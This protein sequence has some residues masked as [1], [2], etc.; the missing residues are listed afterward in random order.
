MDR[1]EDQDDDVRG[2]VIVSPSLVYSGKLDASWPMPEEF[3]KIFLKISTMESRVGSHLA[4]MTT[5]TVWTN[6]YCWLHKPMN[7][8]K[9]MK[10][11]PAQETRI[12]KV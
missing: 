5:M 3:D 1:D 7:L 2:R 9:H 12:A 8:G 10:Q 11:R 4:M 6:Y